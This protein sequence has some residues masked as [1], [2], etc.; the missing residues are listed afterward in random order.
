MYFLI[1]CFTATQSSFSKL[2]SIEGGNAVAFNTMKSLAAF[3]LFASMGIFGVD[4]HTGTFI[5][6]IAYG[7]LLAISMHSGYMALSLG[8]V[9]L[10]S[11]IVSFSVIIPIV[12]GAT[13]LGEKLNIFKIVGMTLFIISIML[14]NIKMPT[15]QSKKQ[16][17]VKWIL[18]VATTFVCNGLCSVIQKVHQMQ[19]KSLYCFEF[20]LFSMLICCIFFSILGIK[21]RVLRNNIKLKECIYAGGAG[22]ANALVGYFTLN[23]AGKENATVLF[24][25][26][27]AG[28]ILCSLILGMVLF[29]EKL[30]LNH[31]LAAACSISAVV[32]LK[33]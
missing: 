9:S 32:F 10:S 27:S 13:A 2:Y 15:S 7:V 21:E 18:F 29:K 24:P 26:I 14:I 22:V 4:F 19:Y 30:K 23:L 17:K 3:L 11:M 25:A 6:S 1:I 16:N 33:I 12:F 28:T 31:I 5:Y 20:T 8:P